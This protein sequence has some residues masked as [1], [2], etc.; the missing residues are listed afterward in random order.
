MITIYLLLYKINYKIVQ[1]FE[2][3]ILRKP[4]ALLALDFIRN[5]RKLDFRHRYSLKTGAIIFDC[6]GF[7]GDWTAK[8]LNLYQHLNP[9]IYVFEIAKP[10]IEILKNRFENNKNV[11]VFG[12]GLGSDNQTIEFSI[13]DIATSIYASSVD[14]VTESGEIKSVQAFLDEQLITQIDLLKMNI[15][16]GEYDLLDSLIASGFV[17]NCKNIQIQFHNYGEWSK[18]RRDNIKTQLANTHISTYDYEWTFEN[19]E[20]KNEIS[21]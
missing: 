17:K 6:G 19:W 13:S 11:E 18:V 12:F 2:G 15:E 3:Y 4:E 8:M 7:K 9:K 14:A 10:Y 1:Y 5:D 16:G 20:L 21:Q